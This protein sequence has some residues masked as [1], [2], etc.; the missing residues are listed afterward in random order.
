[1]LSHQPL[2]R[3]VVL[4]SSIILLVLLAAI[5]WAANQTRLERRAELTAQSASLATSVSTSLDQYLGAAYALASTLAQHRAVRALDAEGAHQLFASV[6]HEQPSIVNIALGDASARL[7]ATAESASPSQVPVLDFVR[8]A[9][10]TNRPVLSDLFVATRGDV[11]VVLAY[12]VRDGNGAVGGLLGLALDLPRIQNAFSSIPLPQGSVVTVMDRSGRIIARSR[13]SGRYVGLQ[14]VPASTSPDQPS[15]RDLDGVER[16]AADAV[17]QRVPWR[18]SVG[19]P[20]SEVR[21]R[22][23][24]NWTRNVALLALICAASLV[25][26]LLMVMSGTRSLEA[27]GM[28]ARRIAEG[29]LTPPASLPMPNR[30]LRQLQDAFTTMAASLRDARDAVQRQVEQERRMNQTLQSLQRH[31]V[32]QERQAAVGQLMHGVAHEM[33][34]PLQAILG[35]AQLLERHPGLSA[36]VREEIAFVQSQAVRARE[37][38]RS[39]SSFSDPHIGPPEPVDLREVV[40]EVLGLRP[41]EPAIP[42]LRINADAQTS[43][44]VQANFTELSRVVLNLVTNAEQALLDAHTLNPVINIRLFDVGSRVRVEVADNGPGVPR[45]LE[46]RLFQ[47]F[48]TTRRVGDGAGLGL[49]LSHGIIHSYGGTIGYYRNE[50]GG[51]TF[52]FELPAIATAHHAH[53][54]ADLLQPASHSGV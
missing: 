43:A 6:L 49:S 18:V 46:S 20:E 54:R 7:L 23:L 19:I 44:S 11:M 41:Q 36:D 3:Q 32:R 29:D 5:V 47:P 28:Q 12:P 15:I 39:L 50:L 42:D 25:A 38:I 33:N 40:A 10:Q 26:I 30:E 8:E 24:S 22:N 14:G 21:A 31:V 53:D 51:A 27:L 45:D 2:R 34:N 13:D 52:Y 1:M 16:L 4:A 17:L 9:L 48:V 35:T 37:I